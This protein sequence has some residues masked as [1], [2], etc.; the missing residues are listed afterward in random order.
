MSTVNSSEEQSKK[1]KAPSLKRSRN[2]CNDT[3]CVK[4]A[5]LLFATGPGAGL[6]APLPQLTQQQVADIVDLVLATQLLAS[7]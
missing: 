3:C 2:A 5:K 7:Q 4:R 6:W 1:R